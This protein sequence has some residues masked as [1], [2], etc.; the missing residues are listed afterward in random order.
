MKLTKV[1]ILITFGVC[2]RSVLPA[3]TSALTTATLIGLIIAICSFILLFVARHQIYAVFVR[4]KK[5][6]KYFFLYGVLVFIYS[7]F[8]AGSYGQW[9]YLFT[10]YLPT[11][12]LPFFIIIGGNKDAV[13][14]VI[15]FLLYVGL[16]LSVIL[17]FSEIGG[18][19]DFSH[20]VGFLYLF[21]LLSPFLLPFKRVF[22]YALILVSVLSNIDNRSNILNF[23]VVLL[24]I[25]AVHL[26]ERKTL[27]RTF[28]FLRA[29]FLFAPLVLLLLGI[30]GLFNV[31]KFGDTFSEVFS[32]S[33]KENETLLTRDTRTG[34]FKDALSAIDDRDAYLFGISAAGVYKTELVDVNDDYFDSLKGGRMGNEVGILE[35]LLRGGLIYV[36][37]TF[38]LYFYA[39][40][41]AI[42]RSNNIICM[43]IGVFIAF[44]WFFLF[45]ESQPTLNLVNLADFMMIGICLSPA[46]RTMNDKEIRIF[47][48]QAFR[49]NMSKKRSRRLVTENFQ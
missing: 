36:V 23:S 16:P 34:I 19:N 40:G 9:R 21:L 46:L 48:R 30:S 25:L 18:M 49:F 6:V 39:S 10:V 13:Q 38:L 29:F 41:L 1:A 15:R 5:L 32:F 28:G 35:Y 4:H 43:A 24:V 20:Y 47:I 42:R 45:I 8:I 2:L 12:I 22:L 11:L 17:Y 33:Y 7:F 27:R 37:L 31:F 26:F 3:L 14:V 44:R